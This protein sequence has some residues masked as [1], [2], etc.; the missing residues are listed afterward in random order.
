MRQHSQCLIYFY[1]LF[2]IQIQ[3]K[4]KENSNCHLIIEYH[5]HQL[6]TKPRAND[7]DFGSKIKIFHEVCLA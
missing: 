3:K 5:T 4:R 2:V 7:V 6:R 1:L